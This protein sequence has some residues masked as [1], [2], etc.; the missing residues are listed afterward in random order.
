MKIMLRLQ[1]LLI[2]STLMVLLS[3]G[4]EKKTPED[5]GV[6]DEGKE[7]ETETVMLE[8]PQVEVDLEDIKERGYITAI[9]GYNSTSYFIYK[10]QPMGY[11]Y[12]LLQELADH[13]GVE[14][15][16]KL[17]RNMDE[18]FNMLNKGEGD[19]IAY[20]MTITNSRKKYV[21]FTEYHNTIQQVLVQRKP[22][23]WQR[24][25]PTNVRKKLVDN[26][27]K[28]LD[29]D[30]F[31][32]KKSSYYHRLKNLEDELGGDI[33]I[34]TVKGNKSTEELIAEVSRGEIP[35]TVADEN[36]ARINNTFLNNLDIETPVSFPQR[37]AWA[38]RK[39]SPELLEEANK[40]ILSVRKSA[41]YNIIYKKYFVNEK[42]Y[43]GRV[44]SE[45]FS[46]SSDQISPYDSLVKF[47]AKQIDWDWR[48]ISSQMYQESHFN[49]K[50]KSWA[51]AVGLMQLMP[52]TGKEF[53]ATDPTDPE[54]SIKAGVNFIA[55][56]EKQLSD[57]E[58]DAE[59]QKFVLASY[60]VGLGHM[61]DAQRLTEKYGKDPH[62]W[63]DNVA[64]YLKNKSQKKYYNDEV[65]KYGYCRGEEPFYYVKNIQARY[66]QYK[67]FIEK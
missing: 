11:E 14:L 17:A 59:R 54:Q 55:W 58:D 3:C 32:R 5:A 48:L 21:A 8:S 51:G 2:C 10:G 65:V 62:V 13:L 9:T 26:V 47:Y 19:I 7:A 66:E 67:S 1:S 6:L 63:E 36:I 53:G 46:Q 23:N 44:Q 38:T 60:N 15:K 4:G 57:I 41:L 12:E 31:V 61:R 56:L 42:S 39:N 18:V 28:L 33:N 40:W 45:F 43:V 50:E 16:I 34:Q 22:E 25:H 30:V 20:G 27:I 52:R 64:Y 35:R 29:K 49:P 37:I 24:M